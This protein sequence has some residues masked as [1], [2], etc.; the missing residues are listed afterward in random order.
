[1]EDRVNHRRSNGGAQMAGD[2]PFDLSPNRLDYVNIEMDKLKTCQLKNNP[3]CDF[4]F[5]VFTIF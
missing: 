4:I 3:G 2:R 5:Y 1:M